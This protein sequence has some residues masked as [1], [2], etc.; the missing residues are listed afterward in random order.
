[1]VKTDPD[2]KDGHIDIAH[3]IAEA[4]MRI[5]LSGYQYR[6][7]WCIIRKTWGWHKSMDKIS[8]TL[9]EKMTGLKRQ[10]INRAIKELEDRNMV[11]VDRNNRVNTYKFNSHYDTWKMIDSTNIGTSSKIA[12]KIVAKELHTKEKKETIQ[13]KESTIIFNYWNEK[14]IIIHRKLDQATESSINA[15]LKDNSID[16]I[17]DSI[18]YYSIILKSDDYRWSY[19]WTLKEFMQKGF[20]MFKD[21]DIAHKNYYIEKEKYN[22]YHA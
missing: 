14:E 2:P 18:H 19:A 15:R 16:K 13:K 9:F 6:I 20:E 7:I 22:G 5:N 8:L 1:M 10:H 3:E 4:L 12:T 21:W 17:R 11:I